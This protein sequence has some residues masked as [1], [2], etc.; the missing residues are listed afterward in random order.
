MAS[1]HS[2]KLEVFSIYFDFRINRSCLSNSRLRTLCCLG[3]HFYAC[4]SFYHGSHWTPL[5]G[6][7]VFHLNYCVSLGFLWLLI[8]YYIVLGWNH[9]RLH[10]S[11]SGRIPNNNL[12]K[13]ALVEQLESHYAI[14][15]FGPDKSSLL[16]GNPALHLIHTFLCRSSYCTDLS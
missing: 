15:V 14:C 16:L 12:W 6:L 4:Y 2:G 5:F 10:I 13:L 1:S 8:G 9:C 11:G 7:K 3:C